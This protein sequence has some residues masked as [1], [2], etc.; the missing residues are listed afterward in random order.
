[1]KQCRVFWVRVV[2]HFVVLQLSGLM[3][4]SQEAMSYFEHASSPVCMSFSA[5]VMPCFLL[6]MWFSS[7]PDLSS[8]AL[9]R[10]Q[11]QPHWLHWHEDIVTGDFGVGF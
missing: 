7:L 4:S 6:Q 8:A 10:N 2:F 3:Q 11:T 1:M 5:S 9:W